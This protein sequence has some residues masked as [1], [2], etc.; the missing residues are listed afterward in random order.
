[1]TDNLDREAMIDAWARP[2]VAGVNL[3]PLVPL[4]L[5]DA[6]FE[7]WLQRTR[8]AHWQQPR[9][10]H[11]RK[12]MPRDGAGKRILDYGCGFGMDALEYIEAG[13][14]VTVAD[15]SPLSLAVTRRAANTIRRGALDNMIVID[16]TADWQDA[17][18]EA[19]PFDMIAMNGVLHHVTYPTDL[20]SFLSSRSRSFWFMVY[21]DKAWRDVTAGPMPDDPE[22]H[23]SFAKFSKAMD[24]NGQYAMAYSE[25]SFRRMIGEAIGDWAMNRMTWTPI[26]PDGWY[27]VAEVTRP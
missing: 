27:A 17:L 1:M 20:L 19:A 3:S 5:S 16:P 10:A 14:Q 4:G 23:P 2:P 9:A 8:R 15:I 7:V 21:T 11:M 24:Q 18:V 6:M 26:D 12:L 13:Y 22:S 25:D